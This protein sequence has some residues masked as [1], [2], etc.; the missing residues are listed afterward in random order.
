ML[1]PYHNVDCLYCLLIAV[2][3]LLQ[4]CRWECCSIVRLLRRE[5]EREIVPI[6]GLGQ[7]EG[8]GL[9]VEEK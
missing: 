4:A 8:T 5:V 7:M 1:F 9:N 3:Q 2:F 6:Q